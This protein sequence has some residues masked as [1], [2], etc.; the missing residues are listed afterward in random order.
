MG[1]Y[2][3]GDRRP[4]AANVS[5]PMS[6]GRGND[7]KLSVERTAG[8]C[9]DRISGG[10]SLYSRRGLGRNARAGRLIGHD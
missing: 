8:D 4:Q 10:R 2:P 5:P 3:D 7:D 9:L 6:S 1:I